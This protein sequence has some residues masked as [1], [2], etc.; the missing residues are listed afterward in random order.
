MAPSRRD[1]DPHIERVHTIPHMPGAF[2][3]R[4]VLGWLTAGAMAPLPG[5]ATSAASCRRRHLAR[6]AVD[7]C[8]TGP[9]VLLIGGLGVSA[10]LWL[11]T[12]AQLSDRFRVH[13]VQLAG[14]AGEPARDNAAGQ[15]LQASTA[16]IAAHLRDQQIRRAM[17]IGHSAGGAMALML[18]IAGGSAIGRVMT[19][20]AV[21]APGF[22]LS[23][24]TANTEEIV[25]Q[26][27]V[28]YRTNL[29]LTAGDR[30]AMLH[31]EAAESTLDQGHA[32]RIA[33]WGIASDKAVL[34]R[35]TRELDVTD[36]RAEIASIQ[37]PITV[38]LADQSS[39]GAPPG[40]MRSIFEKQYA[41]AAT[42]SAFVEITNARHFVMLDQ[43]AAFA[44][45]VEN[46]VSLGARA[47]SRN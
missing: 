43:P 8:G 19:V 36:L 35:A 34:S 44:S 2:Q 17:I 5:N 26:A 25:R 12:V 37:V 42:R 24:P 9:D 45:A 10:D 41:A 11:P 18:A 47:K 33:Q 6:F 1:R 31:A 29:Q 20:D 39:L 14:F 32:H 40:W 7:T 16:S 15:V 28:R 46:F 27:D 3:R 13:V 4:A 22:L 30:L 21:P 38:V 23:G